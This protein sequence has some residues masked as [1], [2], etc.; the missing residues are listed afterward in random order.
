MSR[1]PWTRPRDRIAAVVIV[2]LVAAALVAV[3]ATS[4]SRA[5]H[6]TTAA[7]PEATLPQPAGVPQAVTELWRE[8]SSATPVP[9]ADGST[10]VTG[11]AGVV[12]GRD[13]MTGKA[14]WSYGRDLD[15]CTMGGEWTSAVAVYRRGDG[16]SEVTRLGIDTGRRLAQRN[17]DA[18]S[19]TRL[20]GD[21]AHV[22]AT[23]E[24]VLNVWS[25]DLIRTMEFGTVPAPV[26]PGRQPR[27]GC[28]F[29]SVT[30]TSGN[31]GV[32]ERCPDDGADRITVFKSTQ[33]PKDG[34]SDEPVVVFSEVLP[35]ADAQVIAVTGGEKPLAAVLLQHTRQLVVYDHKGKVTAQYPIRVPEEDLRTDPQAHATPT[36]RVGADFVWFS[37]S[38]SVALDGTTL[39]PLWTLPGT[40][41]PG[42]RFAGTLVVPVPDGVAVLNRSTGRVDRVVAVDR[43]GYR[44]P[45]RLGSLGPVLLEQ[46]GETLVA[47]R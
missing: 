12:T 18:E 14:R 34:R 25:P 13:P 16:C 38:A 20:L 4:D 32:L 45:V 21:G 3:W 2:L 26:E 6:S 46:R 29:G 23:G 39:E 1:S 44:G 15:L 31:I 40:L 7:E 27:T 30:F 28:R 22:V 24:R 17:G 36:T 47:L 37:G 11:Q 35:G 8:K 5:T 41:G 33:A 42:Y 9:V 43:Q 19:P 10:A